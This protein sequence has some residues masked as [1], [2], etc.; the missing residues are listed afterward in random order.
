MARRSATFTNVFSGGLE[1]GAT[2]AKT[3]AY[4]GD[5]GIGAAIGAG[6]GILG[7]IA[8]SFADAPY[9]EAELERMYLANEISAEQLRQMKEQRRAMLEENRLKN[10]QQRKQRGLGDAIAEKLRDRGAGASF[11]NTFGGQ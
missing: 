10:E 8:S 7:G 9:D 4:F 6:A 1:G 5:P 11:Q 3:G 2:G